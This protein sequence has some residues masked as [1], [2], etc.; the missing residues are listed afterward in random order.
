MVAVT[1][2][3][4]QTW[5]QML[6]PLR[7]T[8]KGDYSFIRSNETAIKREFN[9]ALRGIIGKYIG[10][11]YDSGACE[12]NHADVVLMDAVKVVAQAGNR[13]LSDYNHLF[14]DFNSDMKT[15]VGL[16]DTV[17]TGARHGD[18][19]LHTYNLSLHDYNVFVRQVASQKPVPRR[20]EAAFPL[21]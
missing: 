9:P 20:L 13:S 5:N 16:N 18:E 19:I 10:I 4:E 14:S 11:G 21:G 12:V 6:A 3:N 15:S 8:T 1:I 7:E 2:N 17:F